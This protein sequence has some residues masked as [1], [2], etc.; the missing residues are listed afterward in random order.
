MLTSF[1][2]ATARHS[3]G[4]SAG[5]PAPLVINGH[6]ALLLSPRHE[7][8]RPPLVLLGGTAQWLDSWMGHLSALSQKRRVLVYETRGQAGGLANAG[9]RQADL[10][11]CSLQQHARDFCDVLRASG[12]RDV[13]RAVAQDGTREEALVDV[14]AFSFG[15]RVAMAA[16]AFE[17]PPIRRL[18]VTGVAA[19]RGAMGR[20]ALQSWRA[21]LAA[22]DVEG[23]A[24]RRMLDTH[25]AGYFEAKERQV[26]AMVRAVTAANS[27]AGLRAIVDE[28]HTEDTADPTHPLAMARAIRAAARVE[29]GLLL[30]GEEDILSPAAAAETLAAEAGGWG[31]TSIPG[32]AHAVPIEQS[33]AWRRAVLGFLDEP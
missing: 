27:L 16:A 5:L 24:W 29:S 18:C 30:V 9:S 6:R 21:S 19:E 13:P 14:V 2:A 11:D 4:G 15:A 8:S 31:Y 33:V 32:A 25:S 28:S 22:G 26:G 10:S 3:S 17:G 7:P 1:L 20:L 23:F 12:L